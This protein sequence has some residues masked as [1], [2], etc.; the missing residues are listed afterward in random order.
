MHTRTPRNP[1]D[2]LLSR[3]EEQDSYADRCTSEA[4]RCTSDLAEL[5]AEVAQHRKEATELR[6]AASRLAAPEPAAGDGCN[7]DAPAPGVHRLGTIPAWAG[8]IIETTT[9]QGQF[10][11]VCQNGVF[12]HERGEL[13]PVKVQQEPPA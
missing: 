5:I 7:K 13:V 8:A 6:A 11:V 10:A 12:K 3:A 4:K 2:L 9:V 1:R